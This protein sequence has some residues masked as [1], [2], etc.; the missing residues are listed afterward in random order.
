M[1]SNSKLRAAVRLGLGMGAGALAVGFAPG[2][3]AQGAD[4]GEELEEIIT[5]GSRIK[6]ADLDSASPVTVLQREDILAGGITD[7]GNIIQKM[8]SMSGSPIGTTTNNGGSGAVLID[9]RGMGVNR[10]VTLVNG[11]RVVDGGDF[12]TIPSTMIER[13]EILKDGA[14]AVYGAD[15]VA[16]VVNIITRK[17][18]NGIELS[19]QM[20]TDAGL[21]YSLALI[22]GKSFDRGNFVFGAE[23]VDQEQAYQSDTPWE[24]MQNSY[25]LYPQGCEGQLTAPYTGAPDGGCIYFGSSRIPE[26]RLAFATQG[27]FLIGTPASQPY[28]VGTMI[29]QLPADAVRALE[30]L[31]G[32]FLRSHGKRPVHGR[33]A[34]QQPLLAAGTGACAVH[35]R[36]S[37]P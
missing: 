11:Q 12:Q 2:V 10:T 8:P 33:D 36:R 6:R 26:S 29:P 24:H 27:T 17:D 3:M 7:V 25:Y 14:S 1:T 35:A 13:V 30:Y 22:A 18:F 32:R 20:N 34:D 28:E 21:Q 31:H 9:L 19:G 37:V 4:D 23:Y 5:T 15:A 16:G